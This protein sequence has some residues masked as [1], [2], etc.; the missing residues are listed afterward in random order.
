MT[1]LHK[2]DMDLTRGQ[3]APLL[4]ANAGE[5]FTRQVAISL[6]ADG[7]SWAIPEDA[8]AVIRYQAHN[9]EGPDTTWGIYDTMPDGTAAWSAG[10]NV[11][12]LTLVPQMLASP[13]Q[14]SVDV[15]LIQRE[16]LL[17]TGCFRIYVNRAPA[18]GTQAQAQGYYRVATLERINGELQR[19]DEHLLE[20]D[21][22]MERAEGETFCVTFTGEDGG[23]LADRT[24]G[25]VEAAWQSGAV[26][27]GCYQDRYF[28][29][30]EYL[31]NAICFL[32][33]DAGDNRVT[34]LWLY[35]N[36]T[37]QVRAMYASVRRLS[38]TGA[39]NASYMG[40]Q[41]VTVEIPRSV[42]LPEQA[43]AGQMMVVTGV[44][45]SGTPTNWEMAE[46]MVVASST[47]G[48]AKRFRIRVDDSGILWT[49]EVTE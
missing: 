18:D 27:W 33:R 4:Q 2:I 20:L 14:V 29:M 10:E 35:D 3:E 32:N 40:D 9:Q 8:S 31:G 6:Y 42:P 47:E 13:G 21:A 23:I 46:P 1:I 45:S 43:S 48:S 49:E 37:A 26:I 12:T 36:D 44:D 41:A 24:F 22:A 11:L 16:K 19:M 30:Q 17:G 5:A 34:M 39:V 7:V 38:F 15:M 28:P 25:E